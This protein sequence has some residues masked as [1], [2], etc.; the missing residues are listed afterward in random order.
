MTEIMICI[1]TFMFYTIYKVTNLINNK[2]YIGKHQTMNPDDSYYGSGVAICDAISKHGKENFKKEVL[3]IFETED[4]MNAKEKELITEEFVA[5][6]DT[7]NLGIGGE[8]GPHFRGKSHTDE[9]KSD[10]KS[11]WQTEE[12]RKKMEISM[13]SPDCLEKRRLGCIKG[14]EATKGKTLSD[15]A[16]EN[17]KRAASLRDKS[18]YDKISESV[19]SYYANTP[20]EDRPRK[21]RIRKPLSEETKEKLRLKA[22][23]RN[24]SK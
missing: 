5:R 15:A 24:R 7:Y 13:S 16:K 8:G 20:K 17:M 21:K 2:I 1:N 3:F 11:L 14:G 22:R 23:E 9:W 18:I 6:R 12:Y 19:K 4:A 10:R